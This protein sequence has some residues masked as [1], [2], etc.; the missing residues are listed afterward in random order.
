MDLRQK[1]SGNGDWIDLTQ[2]PETDSWEYDH[3]GMV[4]VCRLPKKTLHHDSDKLILKCNVFDV[5]YIAE[6]Y[7]FMHGS[8]QSVRHVKSVGS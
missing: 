7:R 6:S 8:I 4:V 3:H 5:K 2:S 1:G